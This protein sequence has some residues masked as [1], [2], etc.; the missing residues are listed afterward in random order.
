M[1]NLP[2]HPRH[3]EHAGVAGGIV[4]DTDVPAVVVSVQQHEAIRLYRP[5]DVDDLT[6]EAASAIAAAMEAGAA[7]MQRALAAAA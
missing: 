6:D 5:V 1:A 4:T 2:E 7:A 3:L